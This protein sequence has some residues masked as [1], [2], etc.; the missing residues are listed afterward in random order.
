MKKMSNIIKRNDILEKYSF[1]RYC[2]ENNIDEHS[3]T[4]STHEQFVMDNWSFLQY[5]PYYEYKSCVYEIL[6][7]SYDA[8]KLYSELMSR[9]GDS[10][11]EYHRMY[12]KKATNKSISLKY[13]ELGF[14]DSEEFK[15]LLNLYNY[16]L[17]Y[18][19]E[20]TKEINL[21]PNIPDDLSEYVYDECGGVVYHITKY[22]KVGN[23]KKYGLK[24][25]TGKYR[26]FSERVYF[27]TGNDSNDI[28]N[29]LDRIYDIF[30]QDKT[31]DPST[32]VVIQV[33]LNKYGHKV[34]L[35]RD[36]VIDD[37][38][39][40]TSEYIPPYCFEKIL[41]YNDFMKEIK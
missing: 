19:D 39:Y 9:F 25:K 33:N 3:I 37:N 23:I 13:K 4:D 15:T 30:T 28:R 5:R 22:F 12:N 20:D 1:E 8:Q 38:A 26:D 16:T 6:L 18:I 21:E 35:F 34:T 10:L 31:F 40:W 36:N 27:T 7:S 2:K 32:L 24:P 41:F 14:V 11:V 29:G 17:T